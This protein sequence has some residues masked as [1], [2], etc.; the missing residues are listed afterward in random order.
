MR[1]FKSE[2]K[3]VMKNIE[4]VLHEIGSIF[5]RLGNIV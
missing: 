3:D 4:I 1:E 2:K 5:V